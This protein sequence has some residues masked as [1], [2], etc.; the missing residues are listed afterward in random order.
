MIGVRILNTVGHLAV[1]PAACCHVPF[2]GMI[3]EFKWMKN[4]KTNHEVGHVYLGPDALR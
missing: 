1:Y 2:S 4:R 3:H